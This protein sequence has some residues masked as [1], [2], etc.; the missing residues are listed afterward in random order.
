MPLISIILPVYNSKKE[1]LTQSIESVFSQSFKDFELIIINDAST[2]D[3]EATILEYVTKDKRIVYINN[4]ENLK[5]TKTLNKGLEISQGKYIARIDDDDIWMDKEKLQKQIDFMNKNPEYGLCGTNVYLWKIDG[6][7]QSKLYMVENDIDIRR[8]MLLSTQFS[9]SSI[10]VRKSA[11]DMCGIYNPDYNLME[12]HELWLRIGQKFKLHNIQDF[13]TFYR[14]NP[15]WVSLKNRRQQQRLALQLCWKY[16]KDYPS[17]VKWL[18]WS[19]ILNILPAKVIWRI[20]R[21]N[22]LFDKPFI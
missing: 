13:T 2:N 7:I 8:R 6:T 10:M 12:D 16:R 3:I 11:I 5:L 4:K 18:F 22:R 17:F 14:Y 20:N 21:I 1:R 19:I 15:Q 9:H